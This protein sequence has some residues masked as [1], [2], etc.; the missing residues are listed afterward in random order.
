[1]WMRDLDEFQAA[2]SSYK[3]TRIEVMASGAVGATASGKKKRVM[4]K[5]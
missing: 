5:K 1:M 3:A 4:R 2:W